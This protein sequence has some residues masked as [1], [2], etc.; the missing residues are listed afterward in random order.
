MASYSFLLLFLLSPDDQILQ[1]F[2]CTITL[3]IQLQSPKQNIANLNTFVSLSFCPSSGDGNRAA[4]P[5]T[6]PTQISLNCVTFHTSN[7]EKKNRWNRASVIFISHWQKIQIQI[8]LLETPFK[9]NELDGQTELTCCLF[10]FAWFTS[11]LYFFMVGRYERRYKQL[12]L[13]ELKRKDYGSHTTKR[14]I[15]NNEKGRTARNKV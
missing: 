9:W 13:V 4:K 5:V 6:K 3:T 14:K 2:N 11:F 10:V 7:R 15:S 8:R 1:P 12:V